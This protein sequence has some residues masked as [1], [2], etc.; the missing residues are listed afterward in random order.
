MAPPL[1]RLGSIGALLGLA[2]FAWSAG[3]IAGPFVVGWILDVTRSYMM[4]FVFGALLLAVGVA[5]VVLFGSHRQ[6]K[7]AV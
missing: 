4:A 6:A 2:T 3:G 1:F 5:S 7:A